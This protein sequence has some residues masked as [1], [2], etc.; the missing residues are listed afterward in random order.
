MNVNISSQ[1]R[2]IGLMLFLAASAL[3]WVA[4]PGE[5]VAQPG[6][7]SGEWGGW[8]VPV[9]QR[10]DERFEHTDCT[11]VLIFCPPAM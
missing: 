10:C 7:T 9:E 4:V 11:G 8:Y 3:A 5:V 2:M 6:C 1:R